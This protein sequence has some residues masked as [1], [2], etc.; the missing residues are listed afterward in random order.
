MVTCREAWKQIWDTL[1]NAGI[2]DA[3]ADANLLMELAAGNGWRW[4]DEPLSQME[5]DLLSEWTCQRMEHRPIQYIAG[6][7]PFLDLELEVG[8]GVLVPRADTE[9]VCEA[10]AQRMSGKPAPKILDLCA[11]SGALGLGLGRLLPK[12]KVICVEKSPEAYRYLSRNCALNKAVQPVMGDVFEYQ[13]TLEEDAFDL[14]VSNPPYLTGEEMQQLQPEV[15]FEPAMALDG[16][17]DGLDFY[18]HIAGQYQ[19]ALC[20]GGWLVF[21]IGW[22]Q[23]SAVEGILRGT[24]WT[25]IGSCKDLGGNDRAVWAK[26][27]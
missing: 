27:P 26:K 13:Q 10:A 11:G 25:E 21:E 23:R 24:G 5:Q 17:S 18:R 7:W 8:P 22:Q 14:I 6:R 4:R 16:G 19:K 15:A 12:A 20:S 2:E 1:Q 3:R 9:I